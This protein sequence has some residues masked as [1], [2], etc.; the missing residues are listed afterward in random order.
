MSVLVQVL[1]ASEH[2]KLPLPKKVEKVENIY[3]YTQFP[4][5][6][7]IVMRFLSK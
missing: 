3:I 7:S 2:L 4:I 6:G 1:F 5:F